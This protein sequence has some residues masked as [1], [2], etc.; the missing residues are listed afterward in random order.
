MNSSH[1]MTIYDVMERNG[2]FAANPANAGA[3]N[4]DGTDA[5]KGPV[6]YPKI[7]YHP[8]GE[9]IVTNPGEWI[10]TPEGA[11]KVGVQK[12]MITVTV[13]DAEAEAARLAEGWHLHPA[14]ALKARGEVPPPKGL[15]NQL[16]EVT[17]VNQ[18][19][20]DENTELK[21]RLEEALAKLNAPVPAKK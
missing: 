15:S 12:Q 17:M 14:D 3:R 2:A 11:K 18:G 16:V 6:Q 8:K 7:M 4:P 13:L 5:Y 10:S 9:E 20:V 19:L 21:R 1:R